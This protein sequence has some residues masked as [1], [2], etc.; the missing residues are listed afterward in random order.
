MIRRHARPDTALDKFTDALLSH[1]LSTADPAFT[2]WQLCQSVGLDRDELE[3]AVATI[4]TDNDHIRAA[5]VARHG[6]EPET[7]CGAYVAKYAR[8]IDALLTQEG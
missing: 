5:F 2:T 3:D 7:I 1:V 4:W 8:R 6:C